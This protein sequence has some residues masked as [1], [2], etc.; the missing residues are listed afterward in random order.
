MT[1]WSYDTDL[2]VREDAVSLLCFSGTL[3]LCAGGCRG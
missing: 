1:S 2:L 3:E